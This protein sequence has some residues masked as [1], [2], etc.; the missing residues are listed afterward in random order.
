MMKSIRDFMKANVESYN[1]F[2]TH[3]VMCKMSNEELLNNMH[4]TERAEVE[5]KFKK[6]SRM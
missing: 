1:H 4:P 3:E 5:K 6:K 2:L